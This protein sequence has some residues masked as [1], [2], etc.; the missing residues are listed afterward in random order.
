MC[1]R[2]ASLV[3]QDSLAA[4]PVRRLCRRERETPQNARKRTLP[5]GFSDILSAPARNSSE[6]E[7]LALLLH[8]H[9]EGGAGL[10]GKHHVSARLKQNLGVAICRGAGQQQAV[11]II[12][13]K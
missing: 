10:P 1:G 5:A 9:A 8:G 13:G 7:R 11:G 6:R 12:G 3:Q 2:F 4:F